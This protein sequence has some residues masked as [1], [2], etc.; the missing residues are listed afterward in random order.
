MLTPSQPEPALL[1]YR[2][3]CAKC[4]RISAVIL[5][6]ALGS[7]RRLSLDSPRARDIYARHGVETAKVGVFYGGTLRTGWSIPLGILE[8]IRARVGR[9][10]NGL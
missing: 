2:A 6:L 1:I 4:R 8:A 3:T 5:V 10:V 7:L 9:V